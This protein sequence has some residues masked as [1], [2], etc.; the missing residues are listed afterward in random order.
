MDK[1]YDD[2]LL[3]QKCIYSYIFETPPPEDA[4]MLRLYPKVPH[5]FV[6]EPPITEKQVF[7]PGDTV[8]FHLILIGHAI[9]YLPYYIYT[10]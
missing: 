1:A 3:K 2:Y 10:L 5:P 9:D 7:A 6:N 8:P 4:E